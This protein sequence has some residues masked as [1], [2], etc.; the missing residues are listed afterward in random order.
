[1]HLLHC[2]VLA[3]QSADS[4]EDIDPM[5]PDTHIYEFDSPEGWEEM[6]G[7]AILFTD[8]WHWEAVLSRVEVLGVAVRQ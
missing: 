1:M 6:V 7:R 2:R 4:I 8:D 3:S 5:A